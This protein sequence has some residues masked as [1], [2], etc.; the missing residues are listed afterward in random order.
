MG[1]FESKLSVTFLA[2]SQLPFT[3][4]AHFSAVSRF[5]DLGSPS[6]QLKKPHHFSADSYNFD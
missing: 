1:V 3:N 6:Y 2:I 5:V 4:S